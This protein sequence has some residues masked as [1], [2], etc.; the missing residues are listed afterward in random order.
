MHVAQEIFHQLLFDRRGQPDALQLRR[1]GGFRFRQLSRS[2][3]GR[4]N[5]RSGTVSK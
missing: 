3:C 5:L 4:I 2:R 1:S